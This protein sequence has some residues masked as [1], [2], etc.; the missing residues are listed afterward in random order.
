MLKSLL[1]ASVLT[2][3]LLPAFAADS[4]VY[5]VDKDY[6]RIY[7]APCAKEVL[8]LLSPQVPAEPRALF[9]GAD[10][11]FNGKMYKACWA[12]L[13]GALGGVFVID[14]AGDASMLPLAGFRNDTI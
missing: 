1:V 4:L 5:K 14:E 2:A 13:P 8:D 12:I 3:S 7:D 10:M 11:F 9:K 6:V